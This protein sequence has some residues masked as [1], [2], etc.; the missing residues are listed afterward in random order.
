MMKIGGLQ[1][2]SLIDY[3]GYISAIIFTQGCNFK[4]PYCHNPELVNPDLFRTPIK[5]SEVID[6]LES[7]KGKLDAVS[8]CGGEPTIQDNVIS[9]IRQ[10]KKMGFAV[11]LDTNGSVPNVLKTLIADNMLDFIA[12]DVKAPLDKYRDIVKANVNQDAIQESIRLVLNAKIPYEFRTT[13]VESQ[14]DENDILQIGKMI[15]GAGHY[16]LQNFMAKKT[17][18]KKFAK[19]KSFSEEKLRKIKKQL[20]QQIPSVTIR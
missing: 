4:C 6:F 18:D 8:I 7:R 17:L 13:I 14:L 5:V 15:N 1:R 10:I 3:P 11:K 19:E 16:V 2:V 12:M 9:F 20:E